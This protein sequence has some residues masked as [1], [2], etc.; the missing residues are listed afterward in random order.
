MANAIRADDDR[1]A[2]A[3]AVVHHFTFLNIL[4]T[5]KSSIYNNSEL[6][7]FPHSPP[8]HNI[9]PL[10]RKIDRKKGLNRYINFIYILSYFMSFLLAK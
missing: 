8:S 5:V 2:M 6:L 4:F 1:Y 3:Y 9:S 7:Y 10:L